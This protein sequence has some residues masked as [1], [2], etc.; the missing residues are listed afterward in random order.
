MALLA[1]VLAAV[2]VSSD[3]LS[4][5]TCKICQLEACIGRNYCQ[6]RKARAGCAVFLEKGA[7]SLARLSSDAKDAAAL[8]SCTPI[9]TAAS[10]RAIL[11]IKVCA[12]RSMRCT[13]PAETNTR[14]AFP[15]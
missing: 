2:A 9:N 14:K 6:S 10:L 8:F 1:A 15:V 5:T 12:A 11:P 3:P 7:A 13:N 4:Y